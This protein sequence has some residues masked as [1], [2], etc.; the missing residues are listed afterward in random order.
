M[1][2]FTTIEKYEF[3]HLISV[4][5]RFQ[6]FVQLSL[7]VVNTFTVSSGHN[8]AYYCGG[9]KK[10]KNFDEEKF[11][12]ETSLVDDHQNHH[13]P[14]IIEEVKNVNNQS[15]TSKFHKVLQ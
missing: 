6:D 14:T 11:L 5:S 12:R 8:L 2:T 15:S 1:V 7:N 3:S 13:H 9:L 4:V 10:L